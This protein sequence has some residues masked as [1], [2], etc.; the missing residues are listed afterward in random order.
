MTV[1]GESA[2]AGVISALLAMDDANG[3]FTR[4]IAQSVPG[5]VFTPDLAADITR[6]I[7]AAA[8]VPATYEALS[9]APTRCAWS[10]PR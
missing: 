7:A 8:G 3:L 1:F 10:T 4:A 9:A 2:G 5:T 6:A